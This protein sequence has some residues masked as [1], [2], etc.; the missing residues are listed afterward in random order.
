MTGPLDESSVNVLA[1]IELAE[2]APSLGRIRVVTLGPDDG[3]GWRV[4]VDEEEL[5][6]GESPGNV[7]LALVSADMRATLHA[8]VP[9]EVLKRV[10]ERI[11]E[12]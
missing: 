7:R 9:V 12:L 4:D 8:D 2:G 6:P 5:L 11:A 3:G 10:A 1:V